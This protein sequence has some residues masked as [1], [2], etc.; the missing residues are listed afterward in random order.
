MKSLNN[1]IL[2][3]VVFMTTQAFAAEALHCDIGV[4]YPEAK[5]LTL[6]EETFGVKLISETLDEDYGDPSSTKGKNFEISLEEG[7]RR[8]VIIN[9][10]LLDPNNAQLRIDFYV[11][12]KD[13]VLEIRIDAKSKLQFDNTEVNGWHSSDMFCTQDNQTCYGNFSNNLEAPYNSKNY[14]YLNY[15]ISCK[16]ML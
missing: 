6:I 1:I 15:S 4:S 14:R 13:K 7:D 8:S 2:I 9:A 12:E 5:E 11:P 3:S 10:N 16:P